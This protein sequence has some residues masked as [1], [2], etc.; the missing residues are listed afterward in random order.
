[1]NQIQYKNTIT[2]P[3]AQISINKPYIDSL[4]LYIPFNK[5]KILDPKLTSRIQKIY[6]DE[7]IPDQFALHSTIKPPPI[8][9]QTKD[10][11]NTYISLDNIG[12]ERFIVV[13][14]S[15]KILR[16]NYFQ[17][18][19]KHTV[20]T[21][22]NFFINEKIFYC[23]YKTFLKSKPTDID[24]SFNRKVKS[25]KSFHNIIEDIKLQ[26]GKNAEYLKHFN[27]PTNQGLEF[28]NRK[29]KFSVTKPHITFYNKNLEL[30]HKSNIF[31]YANIEGLPVQ[32]LIRC[33]FNLKNDA[34]KKH[35]WAKDILPVF[36]N[37]YELL[38]I[39]EASVLKFMQHSLNQYIT[40][41]I[42]KKRT[43]LTPHQHQVYIIID[44]LVT[45]G[46]T[47]G[48]IHKE[49]N[50]TYRT[51][52]KK[53]QTNAIRRMRKETEM[54]HQLY[55]NSNTKNMAKNNQNIETENFLNFIN[56]N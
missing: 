15:A 45:K 18:I 46:Y 39:P 35:V 2:V 16:K 53:S 41:T 26:S 34:H 27:K 40:K 22:Y 30:K 10:G 43:D 54:L 24:F 29:S 25:K 55:I 51:L 5:C 9:I 36:D 42:R 13:L 20:K 17:G 52:V 11:I 48:S 49:L 1:M 47:L 44:H 23:K 31:Y 50:D 32:N 4:R 8:P 19:T 37:L 6:E 33:E 56:Q 3:H 7:S 38:N 21:L 14:C 28:S 12:K